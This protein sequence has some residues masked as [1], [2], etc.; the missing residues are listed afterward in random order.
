MTANHFLA[1]PP[2]IPQERLQFVRAALQ[3]S[4][5]DSDFLKDA[6]KQQFIIDYIAPDE[7]LKIATRFLRQSE[8]DKDK[9]RQLLKLQTK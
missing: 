7:A 4:V 6:K 5:F 3:R 2:G 9:L 8:A 1:G